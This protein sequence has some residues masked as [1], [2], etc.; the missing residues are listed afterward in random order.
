M[1]ARI[2]PERV[3][4]CESVRE[5][6]RIQQLNKKRG[7]RMRGDLGPDLKSFLQAGLSKIGEFVTYFDHFNLVS[8][9]DI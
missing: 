9:F 2:K 7:W 8:W 3:G 6:N 5:P 1:Q 4:C